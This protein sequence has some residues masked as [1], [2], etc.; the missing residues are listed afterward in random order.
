MRDHESPQNLPTKASFLNIIFW[1][2]ACYQHLLTRLAF[3]EFG[4]T[5]PRFF[6]V[7]VRYCVGG[8]DSPLAN[9]TICEAFNFC[10]DVPHLDT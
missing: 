6:L 10:S 4:P 1:V 3:R 7:F 5:L 8:T 2:T 9:D